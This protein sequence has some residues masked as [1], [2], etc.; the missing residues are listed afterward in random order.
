MNAKKASLRTRL[1]LQVLIHVLSLL[2]I[3]IQGAQESSEWF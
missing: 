3:F 1:A 2:I